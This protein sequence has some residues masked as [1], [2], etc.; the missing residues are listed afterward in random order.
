ME[1]TPTPPRG[2]AGA[3][4]ASSSSSL[5]TYYGAKLDQLEIALRE[6]AIG[7]LR[8]Q[9]QRNAL[10]TKG[11]GARRQ[12]CGGGEPAAAAAAAS[13]AAAA[14]AVSAAVACLAQ[15]GC[16]LTGTRCALPYPHPPTLSA[17]PPTDPAARPPTHPR[18]QC[19][20]CV[21]SFTCCR[22][23]ARTWARS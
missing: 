20:T 19:G 11:E 2:G 10:N 13:A 8:L 5:D 6:K 15:R 3:A 23:P 22:S 21:R 16:A 9:A 7:L 17:R 1:E 14:A 4:A 18:L 12:D